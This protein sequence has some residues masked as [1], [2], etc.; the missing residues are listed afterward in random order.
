MPVAAALSANHLAARLLPLA[1]RRL[2]I[3]R[4]ADEAG[5]LATMALT[6]RAVA[7]GVEAIPLSPRLGDFNE[8]LR[9]LGID[10]LRE[11]VRVQLVPHDVERF[12]SLAAVETD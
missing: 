2:Y 10:E 12:M 3:A 6:E 5:D 11:G 7:A 8:D 4:D 1:L 9:D